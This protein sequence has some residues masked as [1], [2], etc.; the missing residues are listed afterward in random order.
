M[1]VPPALRLYMLILSESAK[2]ENPVVTLD[3]DY[4]KRSAVLDR[5][6]FSTARKVLKGLKLIQWKRAGMS[7]YRYEI[8][9]ADGRSLSD[10]T[11]DDYGIESDVE[12][13]SLTC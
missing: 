11:E 10:L 7:A 6:Y 5:N 8:L 12:Y 13:A 1:D 3:N 9:N 2:A 4:V